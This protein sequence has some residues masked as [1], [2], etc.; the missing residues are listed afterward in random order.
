MTQ[1]RT[2]PLGEVIPP[3]PPPSGPGPPGCAPPPWSRCGEGR[4]IQTPGERPEP[5]IAHQGVHPY[6]PVRLPRQTGPWRNPE[7]AGSPRLQVRRSRSAPPIPGC[8]SRARSGARSGSSD[9]PIRVPLSQSTTRDAASSSIERLGSL[10]RSCGVIRVSL[11]PKQNTS[12]L[13][14]GAVGG[15]GEVKKGPGEARHRPGDVE[16]QHQPPGLDPPAAKCPM[17]RLAVTAQGAAHGPPQVDPPARTR[18]GAA[19][20]PAGQ[21]HRDVRPPVDEAGGGPPPSSDRTACP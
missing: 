16:D 9:S 17:K 8:G 20:H 11:V 1:E 10:Q 12:T 2:P 15:V 7:T 18:T 13:V 4:A 3:A 14:S 21:V 6:H 5:G 19:H